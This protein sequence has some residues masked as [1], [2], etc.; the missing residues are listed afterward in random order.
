M[1][2]IY[3]E[4]SELNI[5]RYEEPSDNGKVV[6]YNGFY[7]VKN[8]K[9]RKWENKR[10]RGKRKR[11]TKKQIREIFTEIYLLFEQYGIIDEK[12]KPGFDNPAEQI[13]F[14]T[15]CDEFLKHYKQ[16]VQPSSYLRVK[17]HAEIVKEEFGN[18]DMRY[19]SGNRLE[20]Y[21]YSLQS[22]ENEK[23]HKYSYSEVSGR[24]FVI[25]STF[26]RARQYHGL[27]N[28][29][30]E[31]A[32]PK[33]TMNDK[34]RQIEGS[35]KHW[36][37]EE[38]NKVVAAID[39]EIE[40]TKKD[41]HKGKYW[42]NRYIR[43]LRNKVI[44]CTTIW[45]AT[46]K[47][48]LLVFKDSSLKY[49][50]KESMYYLYFAGT[51]T[52]T[53]E[54][55]VFKDG[56][57]TGDTGKIYIHDSLAETILALIDE[58]KKLYGYDPDRFDMASTY[59]KALSRNQVNRIFERYATAA[60]VHYIPP[61]KGRRSHGSILINSDQE[62]TLEEIQERLRHSSSETTRKYYIEIYDSTRAKS[63]KKINK[64]PL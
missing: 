34:L 51:Q 32:I 40:T 49:D 59:G 64:L 10:I 4:I 3:D 53:E 37:I 21:Y 30:C 38:V 62:W 33:R 29:P 44:I 8:I 52:E 46:R 5:K 19:I 20:S 7:R 27:Q 48:E 23:Q 31:F 16:L 15:M 58:H 55:Y 47:G 6:Y 45:A 60:G 14:D 12:D 24:H 54:G 61:H 1:K 25:K 56:T 11:L 39:K 9:T 2:L 28:N 26:K 35:K 43:A 36:T 57:K 41:I 17:R 50:K 13:L 22:G 42:Y 63:A 18:E